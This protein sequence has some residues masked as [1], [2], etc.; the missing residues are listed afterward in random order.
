MSAALVVAALTG[1]TIA[2]LA[3][4]LV[5][6]RRLTQARDRACN[7]R[8]ALHARED[9]IRAL[10]I[11][12]A[13]LRRARLVT[14]G[15]INAA[16]AAQPDHLMAVADALPTPDEERLVRGAEAWLRRNTP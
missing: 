1:A 11:E 12:V 7:L 10:R 16:T 2:A 14:G 9:T 4:A 5:S 13:R 3:M 6:A 15:A 8:V